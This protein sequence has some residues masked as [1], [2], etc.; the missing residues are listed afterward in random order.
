DRGIVIKSPE[1]PLDMLVIQ[2]GVLAISNDGGNTYKNA[3]T[4]DGIIGDKIIGRIIMGTRLIIEDENGIIRFTGSLQEIFDAEGNVRVALGEYEDGK[5][6]IK[7][8]NGAL[9]ITGGLKSGHLDP[10]LVADLKDESKIRGDLR[11]TAPLPSNLSLNSSGITAT[12]STN[13]NNF[14]RMDYRG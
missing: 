11:L 3:I 12:Q 6:G 1:N 8:D 2:A 9:E 5:Y 13:A 10:A 4:K 14:A 7:I